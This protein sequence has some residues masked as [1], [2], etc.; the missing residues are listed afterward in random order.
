MLQHMTL[1]NVSFLPHIL[2]LKIY[3]CRQI[4]TDMIVDINKQIALPV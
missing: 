1:R 2:D 4:Y 3:F